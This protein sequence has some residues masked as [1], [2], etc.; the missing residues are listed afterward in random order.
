MAAEPLQGIVDGREGP[1]DGVL[2]GLSAL[3]ARLPAATGESPSAVWL[4]PEAALGYTRETYR[5][6]RVAPDL[7]NKAKE[8][9]HAE[10]QQRYGRRAPC[11]THR[12]APGLGGIRAA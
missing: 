12:P 7:T 9:D 11:S 2:T 1:W 6:P 5:A 3:I 4:C 10:E 8:G